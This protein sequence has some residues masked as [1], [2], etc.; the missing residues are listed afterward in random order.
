MNEAGLFIPLLAD[1]VEDL[2]AKRPEM[3]LL[4]AIRTVSDLAELRSEARDK[5]REYF[6]IQTSGD[7]L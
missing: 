5:L 1:D 6:G 4:E 7:H 2:M 3:H